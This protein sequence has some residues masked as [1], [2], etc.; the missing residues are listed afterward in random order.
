[1]K[2]NINSTNSMFCLQ[3]ENRNSPEQ[4]NIRF[5]SRNYEYQELGIS[6]LQFSD[7]NSVP[8]GSVE[9]VREFAKVHE[10]A[11]P[12]QDMSYPEELRKY[13][14]RTIRAGQFDEAAPDEFVKPRETKIFDGGIRKFLKEI[15]E[16]P[17]TPCWISEPIRFEYEFRFY[18][19]DKKILGWAQ[20]DD[21]MID[22][23]P[24][25]I[26]VRD[27]IC[28]YGKSQPIGYA[29]DIGETISGDSILIEV[30]DGWALGFYP[31]GRLRP[32]DYILLLTSRWNEIK[33][34]E[35]R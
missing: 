33:K 6:E 8:V 32:E 27:M 29:I 11:M 13:L 21:G 28:D 19:H 5:S 9:F 18:I 16:D 2:C 1:M 4:R 35:R 22:R 34:G 7:P 3:R 30:N 15:P 14:G 26:C 24:N 10:I 17:S 23:I 31:W 25:S 20:Y 12:I